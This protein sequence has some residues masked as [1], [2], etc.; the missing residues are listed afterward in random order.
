M[1]PTMRLGLLLVSLVALAGSASA[2]CPP[3]IGCTEYL[4]AGSKGSFFRILVPDDWDGDVFLVN[5]GLDLDPLSIQPHNTCKGDAARACT[6]N[7]QC[8]GVGPGVCN[9]ISMIGIDSIVLP[10]G[11]AVGASTYSD[12]TWAVF[13]SRYDLKDMIRFMTKRGPGRPTRIIATGYSGGGGVTV[14]AVMRLTPGKLIHGAIPLCAASPGGLPLID[15]A[16]DFRLVYDYLCDDVPGG[17]FASL[18]DVGDFTMTQT[19][20]ALRANTCLGLLAASP[21]PTEAAAQAARREALFAMTK[22][23]GSN[24]DLFSTLGFP[25][26]AMGDFVND[27]TRLNGKRPG[28]NDMVDYT[29]VVG[30][31]FNAAVERF[32]RGPGRAKMAKNTNVDFTR[33]NGRRVNYPIMS[34]AGTSDYIV[35]PEFQKVFA[36]SAALGGKDHAMIWG[37]T[38]GHCLFTPLELRAVFEEYLEW[39]DS[40]GTVDEDQPTTADVL[41]RCLSLPGATPN[42]C[43]FDTSYTPPPLITRVPARPD[44]SEAA[45]N[46]LP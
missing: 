33:G 42:Q 29:D 40:Y 6:T 21:D 43:N 16:T 14:D 17:S 24:I 20:F 12:T 28:W 46:P 8:A 23:S 31:D 13:K 27:P 45:R 39:L 41:A 25:T 36:D 15:T 7:A 22:F 44:W 19:E 18:P 10:K 3:G 30:A 34:F 32:G 5:H 9:K 11:K 2:Q 1:A 38:G 4:G 37:S 35:L 26:L